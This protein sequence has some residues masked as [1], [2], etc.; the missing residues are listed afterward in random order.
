MCPPPAVRGL[1]ITLYVIKL[2]SKHLYVVVC[3]CV[4]V[5]FSQT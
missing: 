5:L 4:D 3:L 1:M 2:D